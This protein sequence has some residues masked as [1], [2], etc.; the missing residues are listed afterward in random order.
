MNGD[1][2]D[3]LLIKTDMLGLTSPRHIPTLP[4]P[5][6]T[7]RQETADCG[8]T[9]LSAARARIGWIAAIER[10]TGPGRRPVDG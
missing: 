6:N 5:A 1:P 10:R 3:D 4:F 7:D 2:I 8:R 9:S